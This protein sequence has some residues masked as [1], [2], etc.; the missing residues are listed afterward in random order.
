MQTGF[1]HREGLEKKPSKMFV[2]FWLGDVHHKF[3]L[4]KKHKATMKKL[5]NSIFF[6]GIPCMGPQREEEETE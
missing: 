4:R 2:T 1:V 5:V 3:L 6:F